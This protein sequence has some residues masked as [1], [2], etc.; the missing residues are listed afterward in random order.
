MKK[1][2]AQVM[3]GTYDL[4]AAKKVRGSSRTCNGQWRRPGK[5]AAVFSCGEV[6]VQEGEGN[7][8]SERRGDIRGRMAQ[9][10][11]GTYDLFAAKKV[12]GS[13]RACNGQ[14]RAAREGGGGVFVRRGR[15]PGR[16]R[17]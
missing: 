3:E 16:R 4:F 2:M 15:R 5:A 9:V 8:V 1:R 6:A 10:M 17:R 13:S 11:Q 14:W 12:R 7:D